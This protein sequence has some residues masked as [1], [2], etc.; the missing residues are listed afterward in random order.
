MDVKEA[1]SKR[2]AYR[3]L[4]PIEITDKM[5]NE[6]AR[7]A[8][9]APSCF[10]NQPWRFVFVKSPDMLSKLFQVMSPNNQWV[11]AASLL[12]I[13]F[14]EKTLDCLL[15]GREY[16]LFDTGMATALLILR[17]TEMDLVAHPIA[18]FDELK[19]KE[20]LKIPDEMTAIT[21]L[22]VGKHSNIPTEFMTEKQVIVEKQRPR[23]QTLSEFITIV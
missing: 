7:S 20:I 2:R 16:Y 18:G 12:I 4:T 3:A 9:L 19:I 13:V 6:L 21:V 5:I 14:S 1:I 11:K 10:N 22:V 17:A 23:R 15:P 8:Q